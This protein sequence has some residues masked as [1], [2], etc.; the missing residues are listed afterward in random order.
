MN[1]ALILKC[2]LENVG[3]FRERQD[4]EQLT[5]LQSSREPP[6]K[7]W[8]AVIYKWCSRSCWVGPQKAVCSGCVGRREYPGS[9]RT[10][11]RKTLHCL[12]CCNVNS[13][14]GNVRF[15]YLGSLDMKPLLDALAP[16][17]CVWKFDLMENVDYCFK[18]LYWRCYL[19]FNLVLN[20]FLQT[21]FLPICALLCQRTDFPTKRFSADRYY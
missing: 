3:L 5:T 2:I 8:E 17:Q 4:L 6:T 18:I 21:V 9:N 7:C 11:G 13:L 1:H 10:S 15:F 12:H 14:R 19:Y 16:V 20:C